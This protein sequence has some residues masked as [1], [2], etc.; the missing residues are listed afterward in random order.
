MQDSNTKE[1][2]IKISET[3]FFQKGYD[4]VSV[5]LITREV[6]IAKGTF[7]H[8]FP[9]KA[10]LLNE[11][12]NRKVDTQVK[13]LIE[14]KDKPDL[15]PLDRLN[16]IFSNSTKWKIEQL[17]LMIS[18]MEALLSD[19]NLIIRT[20]LEDIA[21]QKSLPLIE[22]I[23]IEGEKKKYFNIGKMRPKDAAAFIVGLSIS[24]MNN[25]SRLII[26]LYEHPKSSYEL[27]VTVESY[28]TAVE[29]LLGIPENSLNFMVDDFIE[30]FRIYIK[31]RGK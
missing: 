20:K 1:R 16:N 3:L 6:G 22:S 7:Y 19:D 12:V 11:I 31:S 10:D 13:N 27:K 29:R 26:D 17:P 14:I 15:N 5:Q 18:I 24:L 23:I 4:K 21:R 2:I 9:S 25:F 28:R 30:A 8:H